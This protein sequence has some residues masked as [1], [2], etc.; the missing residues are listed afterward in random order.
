L[1]GEILSAG[2]D[3]MIHASFRAIRENAGFT[4]PIDFCERL[5]SGAHREGT[6]AMPAFTYGFVNRRRAAIPFNRETSPAV[7]GVISETFRKLPGVFRTSSASHSFSIWGES[8]G[9]ET[10]NNPVSPLGAGSVPD[11][12]FKKGKFG[13]ALIGCGFESLTLLH[14]LENLCSLPYVTTNCW[15]YM[16]VEPVTLSVTGTYPAIELPGCSKGFKKFENWLLSRREL[17]SLSDRFTFYLID[18]YSLLLHFRE[19]IAKDPFA[20][21]CDKGCPSCDSRRLRESQKLIKRRN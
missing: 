4:E 7:T 17:K 21:L 3:I 5:I 16:G 14:Y 11:L 6:L 1:T 8:K 18:P 10:A 9:I 20:L 2:E 13:I 12:L 15:S 19:F